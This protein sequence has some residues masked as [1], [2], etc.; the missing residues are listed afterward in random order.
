MA[1]FRLSAAFAAALCLAGAVAL[2]Q[3]PTTKRVRGQIEAVDGSALTVKTR[4]G[5][6][7]KIALADN[8]VVMGVSK[9]ELSAIQPNSFVGAASVKQPDGTL[10]A[11]EVLVFPESARGSG[12]GHFP[13]DLQPESLMTNATVGSVAARPNGRSLELTY[14]DGKQTVF[15]PDGA[16]IV[17][18]AP[19]DR[20]LLVKG[21][22]LFIGGAAVGADGGLTA[23]RILAGKDGAVPPM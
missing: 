19:A 21:A 17:T 22:Y 12:E 8:L 7:V 16:P 6:V 23:T 15:V 10:R 9:L 20:S 11:L 13:W 1:G 3:Q 4:E 14:K 2:A 5:P 18:F